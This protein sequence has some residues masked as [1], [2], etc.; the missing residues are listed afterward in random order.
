M[1]VKEESEKVGLKLN[2]QKTMIMASG[3]ITSW[4]IDGEQWKQWQTFFSGLGGGA[5]KII[6]DGDCSDEM[7]RCLLLGRKA[8]TKLDSIL[9]SRD[10]T[11]PTK[12]SSIQFSHSVMSDSLGH[13]GLQHAKLPKMSQFFESGGASSNQV[14]QLQL[15]YQSFQ[16]I[17]RTDFLWNWL[18]WSPC[19]PRD[20][21][22]FF[23]KAT[24]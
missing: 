23:S 15:Q 24:V 20:S 11:L 18:V 4:E 1:K 10:I 5:S 22:E 21:Q 17:F 16:W 13:H 2:I 7:K 9:K 12:V 8:L 6:A 3:P 14:L 19:N